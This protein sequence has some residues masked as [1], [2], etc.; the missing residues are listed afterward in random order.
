ME[1]EELRSAWQ[2]NNGP[3]PNE[4]E[5]TPPVAAPKKSWFIRNRNA[6]DGILCIVIALFLLYLLTT[7]P[8]NLLD[9][10]IIL[11]H[12]CG[13]LI[14]IYTLVKGVYTLLFFAAMRKWATASSRFLQIHLKNQLYFIY[15]RITWLWLLSPLIIIAFPFVVMKA[16][17]VA[18][19]TLILYGVTTGM[20]Y[21]IA[22]VVFSRTLWRKRQKLLSEINA[23]E[24][25]EAQG[26]NSDH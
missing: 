6:I 24:A 4:G 8:F 26:K 25:L 21:L 9:K 20:L 17:T 23:M 13:F 18:K 16:F 22:L 2:K 19:E 5:T 12:L 7:H 11:T 10:K 3:S 15:E 1:L 14:A